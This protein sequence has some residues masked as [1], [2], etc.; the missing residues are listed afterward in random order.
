MI[1]LA[2]PIAT[3]GSGL[4]T[5]VEVRLPEPFEFDRRPRGVRQAL[6][7][8][9]LVTG[10]PVRDARNMHIADKQ[11]VLDEFDRK[12]AEVRAVNLLMRIQAASLRARTEES[13]GA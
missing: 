11:A 9:S 7:N 10:I 13:R 5:E 12:L 8:L 3:P 4:I 2:H 1:A 6:F